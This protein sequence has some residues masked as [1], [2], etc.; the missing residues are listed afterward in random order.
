MKD[1]KDLKIQRLEAIVKDISAKIHRATT[2]APNLE[3]VLEEAQRSP[4]TTRISSVRVCYINK[5]KFITYNGLTDPKLFLTSMSVAINRAHFSPEEYD[6]GCSN[7]IDSY[8]ELTAAFLQHHSTFMI[9]GTSNADQ[10]TMYQEDDESLR[11]FMERFKKV[12]SNLAIAN[13]TAISALQNALAYGSR[14]RNDIIIYEPLTLDDALHQA[15]KYIEVPT[16]SLAPTSSLVPT[17]SFAPTSSLVPTSSSLTLAFLTLA[18]LVLAS[19]ALATLVL[20]ALTVD[21]LTLATLLFVVLMVD[22][23]TLTALIVDAL[24]L[25]ALIFDTLTLPVLKLDTLALAYLTLNI[26]I[27]GGDLNSHY[28]W[29]P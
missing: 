28:W 3:K 1:Y 4:F 17:Y 15:S 2:T 27:L 9:K 19:L 29:K 14:F 20:A 12:V 6:A 24:M 21:A 8:Y 25:A 11:E 23:L 10:W 13:D 5:F 16:Y 18:I 26:L 22:V 7:S